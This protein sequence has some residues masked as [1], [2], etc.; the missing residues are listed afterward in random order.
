[1]QK[2]NWFNLEIGWELSRSFGERVTRRFGGFFLLDSQT[3]N[4]ISIASALR[5]PTSKALVFRKM[6]DA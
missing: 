5:L 4:K 3:Q 1:M 2:L 6:L